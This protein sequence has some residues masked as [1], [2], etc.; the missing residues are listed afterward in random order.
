MTIWFYPC[1]GV[2]KLHQ[3]SHHCQW[4][5]RV[6]GRDLQST[7]HEIQPEAGWMFCCGSCIIPM[8]VTSSPLPRIGIVGGF[9]SMCFSPVRWQGR[10]LRQWAMPIYMGIKE[11]NSPCSCLPC[12]PQEGH[13]EIFEEM[14]KW[15][16]DYEGQLYQIF[17]KDKRIV[18]SRLQSQGEWPGVRS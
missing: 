2:S 16:V 12:L 18:V 7:P 10:A 15:H 1:Y 11:L 14:W 6:A 9:N 4:R 8:C 5:R 17:Q 13:R 3:L